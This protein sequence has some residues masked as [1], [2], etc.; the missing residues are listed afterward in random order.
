MNDP[1]E[2]RSPPEVGDE[3]C[4][5]GH[6][7]SSIDTSTAAQ[8]I[9]L[10][11]H[12]QHDAIDTITARSLLNIMHPAMRVKELR[13]KGYSVQTLRFDRHDDQGRIHRRVA[14]YS[15]IGGAA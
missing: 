14:V 13:A 2:R 15:L 8:R 4:L 11:A 1:Q 12:L 9:R 5:G 10:L 7:H 3:V 6:P